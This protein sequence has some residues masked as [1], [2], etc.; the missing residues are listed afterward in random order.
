MIAASLRIPTRVEFVREG[1]FEK[2]YRCDSRPS[3]SFSAT[4]VVSKS[5]RRWFSC[6][7]PSAAR[8]AR[9]SRRQLACALGD[10][11]LDALDL[12]VQSRVFGAEVDQA[13]Q[14]NQQLEFADDGG[15]RGRSLRR[16][17][18][19]CDSVRA[20]NSICAPNCG[21]RAIAGSAA[22]KQQRNLLARRD[23]HFAADAA[24]PRSPPTSAIRFPLRPRHRR[25]SSSARGY[26]LRRDRV[27][28][29][30]ELRRDSCQSS[31]VTNG[32]IGCSS[33]QQRFEHEQ[34]RVA[35]A[36][37][38]GGVA[39]VSAGLASSTNQSQNSFQANSYSACASQVE[40]IAREVLSRLRRSVRPGARGSSVRRRSRGMRRRR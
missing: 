16:S 38:G 26:A 2:S 9:S 23:V 37:G 11:A 33:A 27:A 25:D 13:C 21:P 17:S 14:R 19:R 20:R 29:D 39:A 3:C 28:V 12:L 31:S 35:R 5:L 1:Q 36:V 22:G 30:A 32:I 40:A 15:R 8:S 7:R 24:E 10:F 18:Q 34:Q 6:S 4:S